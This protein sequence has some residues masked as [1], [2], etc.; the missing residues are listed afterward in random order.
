MVV[1]FL[2]ET[3]GLALVAL[4]RSS[5]RLPRLIWADVALGC[6]LPLGQTLISSSNH[7]VSGNAWGYAVTLSCAPAAG[8]ELRH[9]WEA[10]LGA[11]ALTVCYLVVTLPLSGSHD[12]LSTVGTSSL[13]TSR[14]RVLAGRWLGYLRGWEVTPTEIANRRPSWLWQSRPNATA[15]CCTTRPRGLSLLSRDVTDARP[16]AAFASRPPLA[17]PASPRS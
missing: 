10:V 17:P 3:L 11:G 14:S 16:Q 15:G 12:E 9:R 4:R 6:V 2:S 7:M 5:I 1:A 8:V 13:P